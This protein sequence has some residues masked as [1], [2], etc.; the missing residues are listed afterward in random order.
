MARKWFAVLGLMALLPASG[1]AW[2]RPARREAVRA[3]LNAR[4]A[5][6][7]TAEGWSRLGDDVDVYLVE[8]AGDATLRYAARQRAMSGLGSVRGER[9]RTFLHEFVAG[10]A[11]AAPL[12]SSAVQA[13]A[14]GFGK[15]DAAEAQ[16][17]SGALLAHSDWQVRRGAVRALGELGTDEARA[18]LRLHESRE[19]HPAVRIALRSALA[20]AP[21]AR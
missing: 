10:G 17:L 4:D 21:R 20:D 13:Y 14:H 8:A 3:V 12:L 9:A 6:P 11:G 15:E 19:A 1:V 2:A 16:R 5:V 18:M 7:M